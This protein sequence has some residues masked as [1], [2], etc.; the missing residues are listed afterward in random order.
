MSNLNSMGKKKLGAIVGGAIAVVLLVLMVVL[1]LLPQDT[2]EGDTSSAG[3]TSTAVQLI[4]ED[5]STLQSL[6]IKNDVDEYTIELVGESLW[7]IKDNQDFSPNPTQYEYTLS[8]V[9]AV[10]ASQVVLENCEDL[11]E[12]G[13]DDP[14][15]SMEV[16][17]SNGN[18]YALTLGALTPNGSYRYAV[19]T[20]KNTVYAISPS[21]LTV[22]EL[23]RYDYIDHSIVPSYTDEEGNVVDPTVNS[24][25]VERPDLARPILLEEMDKAEVI[26]LGLATQSSIT[27]ALI[28]TSPV[29]ALTQ[30]TVYLDSSAG[31]QYNPVY[32]NFGMGAD[33]VVLAA[34]TAAQLTEMGFDEPTAVMEM[35]YNVTSNLKLTVGAAL[36]A[37]RNITTTPQN[38][39]YYYVMKDGL[40]VV[41]L[42]AKDKITWVDLE[43]KRLLNP[44]LTLPMVNDI[45]RVEISIAGNDEPHVLDV[46]TTWADG[47]TSGTASEAE[48]SYSF[49]GAGVLESNAVQLYQLLLNPSVQDVNWDREPEG[50]PQTTI[51]FLLLD[52]SEVRVDVYVEDD[53]TTILA[54]NGQPDYI[55]RSGFV[56]KLKREIQNIIDYGTKEDAVKAD[57]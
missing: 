49:N 37:N 7:R 47:A 34:P 53:L 27:T 28:M 50:D 39:K 32:D 14:I 8:C 48:H 24:F 25:R 35:R 19:E 41:F 52:G 1:L 31:E 6:H 54:L 40:D 26:D 12:F 18:T 43:P 36:D 2:G 55:G 22:L 56:D 4:A 15:A 33:D 13:F 16:T 38:I 5:V 21:A 30:T 10:T 44:L 11:S 17:F 57:W 20:G 9:T 46:T 3:T 51:R 29:A 42:V 23:D 45:D